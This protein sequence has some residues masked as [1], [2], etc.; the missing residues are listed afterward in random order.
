MSSGASTRVLDNTHATTAL[1]N[2]MARSGLTLP[3][4]GLSAACAGF[5]NLGSCVSAMHVAN[6]LQIPGGFDAVKSLMT[7]GDKLSLGDAVHQLRPTADSKEAEKL[8]KKQANADLHRASA[9]LGG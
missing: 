7:T 2:A 3:A 8:A 6:N 9:T 4:G 1:T 5:H